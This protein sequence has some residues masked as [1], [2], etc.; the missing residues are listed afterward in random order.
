MG[1]RQRR[2]QSPRKGDDGECAE[3]TDSDCH[4]HHGTQYHELAH[5]GGVWQY[6]CGARM[7]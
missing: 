3:M 6:V 4:T 2:R 5:G 7:V 1:R